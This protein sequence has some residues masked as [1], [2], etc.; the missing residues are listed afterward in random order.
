MLEI[1]IKKKLEEIVSYIIGTKKVKPLFVT[2]V[3]GVVYDVRPITEGSI[4]Q[5]QVEIKII[6]E[7]FDK[8][9]EIRQ[10]IIENLHFDIKK[11]SQ[12]IDNIVFRG[13]L[14]GG[15]TVFQEE[16]QAWEISIIFIMTW[17][18]KNEQ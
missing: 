14:S 16:V 4:K 5:S 17:R 18:R 2:S 3:P 12:C 10:K 15:G 9:L 13:E 7:D 1:I 6:H 8:G 11:P